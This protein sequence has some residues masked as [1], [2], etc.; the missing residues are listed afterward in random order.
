MD[1]SEKVTD[2]NDFNLANVKVK[3]ETPNEKDD[4][5]MEIPKE[6]DISMQ[7]SKEKDDF[8][9][10]ISKVKDINVQIPEEKDDL[11]M[12]IPKEKDDIDM[13]LDTKPD[14][15]TIQNEELKVSKGNSDSDDLNTTLENIEIASPARA[16]NKLCASLKKSKKLFICD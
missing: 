2:E 15:T 1:Q 14:D 13:E 5:N 10:N 12:E 4:I 7:I 3:N 9:L 11:N 16:N 6:K 8:T